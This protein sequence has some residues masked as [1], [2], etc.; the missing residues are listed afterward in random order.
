[1]RIKSLPL[2]ER[3]LEKLIYNGQSTLSNAELLALIIHTGTREG[4]ALGLAEEVL[5][6]CSQGLADLGSVT[7]E[8]LREIPGI[9]PGKAGTILAAIELGKRLASTSPL[10]KS[11]ALTSKDVADMFMEPLRYEK[12]EHFKTV[13]VNAKGQ[14]LCVDHVSVGELTGT[15]VHPREV[16]S[17]AV[18]KSAAALIFVH[19]HP[20][21][22]PTPSQE[23]VE[24]TERLVQCGKMLGI[25]VLD[26]VIIGDGAYASMSGL[27]LMDNPS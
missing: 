1:M 27:G 5:G 10:S 7:M 16:F 23:D 21:G 17:K 24:T 19:N 13:L 4:S 25:R 14:V 3:P 9:G 20:S 11:S 2:E 12:K 18:R 26:H 22:D 15:V 8:E 6:R